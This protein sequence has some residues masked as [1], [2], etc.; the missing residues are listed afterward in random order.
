[1]SKKTCLTQIVKRHHLLNLRGPRGP[2]SSYTFC[3]FLQ[4]GMA[5]LWFSKFDIFTCDAWIKILDDRKFHCSPCN[6]T[7][8]FQDCTSKTVGGEE[9]LRK[10]LGNRDWSSHAQCN[11][12]YFRDFKIWLGTI[13]FYTEKV[14]VAAIPLYKKQQCIE[15]H[16]RQQMYTMMTIFIFLSIN[17]TLN[18]PLIGNFLSKWAHIIFLINLRNKLVSMEWVTWKWSKTGGKWQKFKLA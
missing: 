13:F 2:R 6:K 4:S 17:L 1:M 12:I 15:D 8:E 7:T 3:S 10:L 14:T 11:C 16:L 18:W 5:D 9:I